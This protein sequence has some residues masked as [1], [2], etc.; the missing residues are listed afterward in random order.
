MENAVLGEQGSRGRDEGQE[1]GPGKEAM[2]PGVD[3]RGGVAFSVVRWT[4]LLSC[5]G[6]LG[7]GVCGGWEVKKWP[8]R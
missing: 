1:E 3:G 7:M 5:G 4:L 6:M 8:W 2:V